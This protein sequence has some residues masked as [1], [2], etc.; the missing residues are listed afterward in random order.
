MPFHDPIL[1]SKKTSKVGEAAKTYVQVEKI[2]QIVFVLPCA[3]LIGWLGGSWLDHHL[4]Q[5]WMTV[6]GFVFGCAAGFL[7]VFR[8]TKELVSD[9][10][11][12]S[13]PPNPPLSGEK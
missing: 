6:V 4:H 9:P 2:A 10:K 1:S 11:P 7:S 13:G 5:K 8:M 3:V 12:R